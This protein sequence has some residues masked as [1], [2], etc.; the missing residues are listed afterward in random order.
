V[1]ADLSNTKQFGNNGISPFL[2][3]DDYEFVS[4][5]IVCSLFLLLSFVVVLY[6]IA[7]LQLWNMRQSTTNSNAMV[8]EMIASSTSYVF[9]YI[10]LFYFIFLRER[11]GGRGR[12]GER[13]REQ[14]KFQTAKKAI[15]KK[16]NQKIDI[17]LVVLISF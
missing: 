17:Y 10:F 14:S 7:K 11:D 9:L 3:S 15:Y 6:D 5:K 16:E 12:E 1:S 2:V 13:W 4:I 8:F